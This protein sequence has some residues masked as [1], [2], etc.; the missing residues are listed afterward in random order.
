MPHYA[1]EIP[2]LYQTRCGF[3]DSEFMPQNKIQNGGRRHL[4]LLPVTNFLT[5]CRHYTSKL[6]HHT[7]FHENISN[8]DRIIITFRY[9]RWR[10]S[11]M[12]DFLK[13]DFLPMRRISLLIF[14]HGTKFC[15]KILINA[16]I[17]AENRNLR[18]RPS[19]ILELIHHH[20]GPPT[21]CIHWA[22]S[23]RQ[24][25]CKSDALFWK[26]GNL[27]FLQIWLEMPIKP[28]KFWFLGLK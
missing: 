11:A 13:A 4:E 27:N 14:H 22:T 26:Y 3:N 21:Q 12:F 20:I 2:S 16:E 15:A 25:L 8:Y 7:I 5:Y 28:Q 10:S 9:S 24:I 19:A 6:N 1:V 23:A 18:W 17:M